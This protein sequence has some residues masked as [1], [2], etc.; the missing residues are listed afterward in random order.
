MVDNF[1]ELWLWQGWIPDEY[2]DTDIAKFMIER[3]LSI[4]T[5][6]QY[7]NKK[8]TENGRKIYLVEAGSEPI[9]FTNIFPYWVKKQGLN[10]CATVSSEYAKQTILSLKYLL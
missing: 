5:A 4:K 6:I 2:G 7:S 10:K 3:D 9:E 8:Y 1:H